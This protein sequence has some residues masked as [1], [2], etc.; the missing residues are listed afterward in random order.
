MIL[1][2]LSALEKSFY[3]PGVRDNRAALERLL[4]PDFFEFTSSG[5]NLS[6]E[7]V[8]AAVLGAGSV[9]FVTSEFQAKELKPGLILL[10]YRCASGGNSTLRS[11]IW[12]KRPAG[13]QLL[14]H[15]ATVESGE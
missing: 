11:S 14:F 7:A 15:Q 10:T 3:E 13:W 6:R 2:E 8:I 12:E 5:K 4:A 9:P 1:S